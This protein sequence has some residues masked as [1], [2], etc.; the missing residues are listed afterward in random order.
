MKDFDPTYRTVWDAPRIP[1]DLPQ[2][3]VF[4][5]MAALLL[6]NIGLYGALVAGLMPAATPDMLC[7]DWGLAGP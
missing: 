7:A 1:P 5:F 6:L 4:L 3:V 2:T